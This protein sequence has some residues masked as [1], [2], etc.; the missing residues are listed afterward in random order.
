MP[1]K[2]EILARTLDATGVA[3][4]LRRIRPWRGLLVLNYHRIGDASR[5]PFDAGV[6][7]ATAAEFDQQ[8]AWLQRNADVVGLP[9]LQDVF[10]SPNRRAVLLTFDD[11]YRDNYELALPLLQKHRLPAAFFI[12]TGFIDDRTI[13]WWDEIAWMVKSAG[14]HRLPSRPEFANLDVSQWAAGKS[15]DVIRRVLAA[16]KSLPTA[17]ASELLEELAEATGSGRCPRDDESTPWMNW[18][19]I[20]EMHA[21]GH[22][23]AG[24]TVTH[25][26]LSRCS[27]EQ[28]REE[29]SNSKR[30]IEET[31]RAPIQG[32]S[33]PVGIPG[34]Y[35][36]VTARLVR[37]AGYQWAFSFQGG[38]VDF[39]RSI[40]DAFRL[41]RVAMEAGLSSPRFHAL[42]TLP[43]LFA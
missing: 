11:G 21:A 32:F 41:P 3:P 2:K 24:H 7:S 15:D 4:L 43:A 20:Q 38:Y 12:T 40:P 17:Q 18:G 6:F 9:D 27:E 34:S 30:R 14:H 16:Y 25:P 42:N 39:S 1:S 23:I 10:R 19:M 28:Q 13:A 29:I 26:L 31:L 37:E 33:Y 35:T 36:D 22:A 5:T 8:L